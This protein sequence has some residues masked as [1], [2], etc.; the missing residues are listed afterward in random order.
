MSYVIS[1]Q[2]YLSPSLSTFQAF[3]KPFYPVTSKMQYVYDYQDRKYLDLL[4]QNL[5]ISVGHAHPRVMEKVQENFKNGMVHCTTMYYNATTGEAA[6]K[7]VA[8]LPELDQDEWVV[9]FVN[10]GSEAVDLAMLM[11]RS[12]TGCK[13]IVSLRNSY[14]GL[15]GPAMGVTGMSVC[16]NQYQID[17]GVKHVMNPDLKGGPLSKLGISEKEQIKVYTD[18]VKNTIKFE[19]PGK[20]AGFIF[21]QVQGYGGIH[22]L[23]KGYMSQVSQHI[24]EAGGLII[25]DEVQSGFG[26][27]GNGM[28]WS[29]EMYKVRHNH[30]TFRK[31]IFL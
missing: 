22:V 2:R 3:K 28:F 6:K 16:K 20:I 10:S 9:H 29:F 14:H 24:R 12:H 18:D 19:T 15:H 11:A 31:I 17:G 5:T 25:A 21:E 13:D 26:R 4:A 7:L 30:F 1:R 8:T 23:P 27:M